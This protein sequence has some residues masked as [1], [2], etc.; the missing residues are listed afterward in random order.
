[1]LKSAEVLSKDFK[2]CEFQKRLYFCKYDTKLKAVDSAMSNA[3][4]VLFD[5]ENPEIAIY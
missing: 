3:D 2:F 4:Q 1:M 5:T